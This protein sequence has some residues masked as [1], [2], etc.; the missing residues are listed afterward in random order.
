MLELRNVNFSYEREVLRGISVEMCAG[1]I[2][3][4]LGPNGAG[5][6]TL[7]RLAYGAS[8]PAGGE[9]LFD[10]Q[11]VDRFSR[12]EIAQRMSLVGQSSEL[13]FPLTALEY[14]LTGRFAHTAT[15]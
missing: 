6:S 1:E 12:R 15:L 13:R 9:V 4:L 11:P 5:K 2:I 14:V 7:L 3:A 8:K 10:G